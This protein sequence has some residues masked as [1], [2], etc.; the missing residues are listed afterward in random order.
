MNT[1]STTPPRTL[2]RTSELEEFCV[3][4]SRQPFVACDTEF[5]GEGLYHPRLCLVQLAIPGDDPSCAVAVDTL[6]SGMTLDPLKELFANDSVVKVFHSARQ[7]MAIFHHCF[8]ALPVPLFDTQVAAMACGFGDNVGYDTLVKKIARHRI[9]KSARLQDWQR[10]PLSGKLLAYALDDV[11]HLRP[12]YRH[13]SG[14]LEQLGRSHWIDDEMRVVTDIQTYRRAPEDAWEKIRTRDTNGRHL[15]ILRELAALRENLA[16]DQ[17]VPRNHVLRDEAIVQLAQ[18]RPAT[19]QD[20]S[21]CRL[22]PK[23]AKRDR[24]A[25]MIL[26]AVRRGNDCAEADLPKARHGPRP[27]SNRALFELMRVLLRIC[28]EQ[29]H[30]AEQLI[31]TTAELQGLASGDTD[32]RLLAGWRRELYGNDAV[33]LANGQTALAVSGDRLRVVDLKA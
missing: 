4:A 15:A 10:R 9:D 12:V 32:S 1:R 31:A 23:R 17:N 26:D 33:R 30:V 27:P 5:V 7:D 16:R 3:R 24:L 22:L 25:N 19:P 14:K 29:H 18:A 11:I 8:G 13:L 21:N 28:A 20:L 6:S 2:T